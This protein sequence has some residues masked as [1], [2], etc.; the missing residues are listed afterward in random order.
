MLRVLRP[1]GR[2]YAILEMFE[3]SEGEGVETD[4]QAATKELEK[5]ARVLMPGGVYA[6]AQDIYENSGRKEKH[7]K[8]VRDLGL[9]YPTKEALV[10]QFEAAGFGNVQV[11]VEEEKHWLMVS[12]EK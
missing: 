9:Y 4:A 8:Y 2:F 5:A 11:R 7:E 10:A 1:G 6:A 3:Q 12:G